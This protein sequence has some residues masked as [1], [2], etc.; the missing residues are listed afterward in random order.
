MPEENSNN[1]T[2]NPWHSR[3]KNQQV[4]IVPHLFPFGIAGTLAQS[5]NMYAWSGGHFT[6]REC[7]FDRLLGSG[8]NL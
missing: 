3:Y 4:K 6:V 2:D 7:C 1:D 5:C 8:S